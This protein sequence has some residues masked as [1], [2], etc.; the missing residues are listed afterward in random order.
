MWL[1]VRDV[2][3]DVLVV[4]AG[5]IGLETA[6]VLAG[7]GWSVR[8]LDAGP[9]GA[10][11][12]RT[13]PPNTRFFTSPERLALHGLGL[14]TVHQ[15]KLTGEEYLAYLRAYVQTHC[16]TVDTFTRVLRAQPDPV[17]VVGRTLAGTTRT[18]RAQWLVLASGGTHRSR[19]LGVTGEDLPHVRDHLGDPHRYAGRT[20]LIVGGRNSAAESA[21]RC[22]RAGARVHLCHRRAHLH[23]RVKYWLRPEVVSLMEEGLVTAHMPDEVS[24]IEPDCVRLAGGASVAVDDVLLQIG[25]EQDPALFQ[26][27][28]VR[29]DGPR[30]APVVDASLRT[31][32]ERVF[33]VGTA[34]AGTQERFEVFIE[35][36]HDDALRVA[37]AIAGRPAP[38][39]GR[40]RPVPEV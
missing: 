26:M 9:I 12:S 14:S 38:P 28:G 19:R 18:Y 36:S 39:M 15:E 29:C 5:P 35:N 24:S 11:I 3:C 25:Y 21:L 22:Y 6:A 31:N 10:T 4:G 7:E 23:E 32:R 27:L 20:V 17:A 1:L 13:F 33:V 16:L 8:V 37:A 40:T 34:K 30:A 2:E